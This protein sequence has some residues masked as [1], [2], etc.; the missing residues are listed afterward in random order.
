MPRTH[1]FSRLKNK[2]DAAGMIPPVDGHLTVASH[3]YATYPLEMPG[4]DIGE[5]AMN[6]SVNRMLACGSVPRYAAATFA[7]DID[8]GYRKLRHVIDSLKRTAVQAEVEIADTDSVVLDAGPNTGLAISMF[9]LGTTAAGVKLGAGCVRPG[10]KVILTGEVG[11]LGVALEEKRRR[12]M[13]FPPVG[14]D[15]HALNDVVGAALR[16]T[17]GV[18]MMS[19]PATGL[20]E[21]LK[22]ISAHIGAGVDVELDSV[23]LSAAVKGACRESG[24]DPYDLATAGAMLMIV[25]SD[26][27]ERTLEAIRRSAHGAKAAVIGVIR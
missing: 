13:Y 3:I 20:R 12:I 27:A 10:D 22:W 24:L 17:D 23:P 25:R 18:R 4:C 26:D 7:L 14:V 16:V 1:L 11:A 2:A 9:M 21:C 5:F 19:Y 8:T 15:S 6:D